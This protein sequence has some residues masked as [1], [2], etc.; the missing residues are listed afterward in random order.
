VDYAVG[1]AMLYG[2]DPDDVRDYA[3]RDI[4]LMLTMH[5][6]GGPQ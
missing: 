2:H 5:N 3:W 1:V 4:E 6:N